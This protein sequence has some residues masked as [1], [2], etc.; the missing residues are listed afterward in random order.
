MKYKNIEEFKKDQG[1]V[2]NDAWYPRVTKICDV[3]NK[4][5]LYYFYAAASN[6][7]EANKMKQQAAS[8]GKIVHEIIESFISQ[9]PIIAPEDYSGFHKAFSDF[10]KHH[11]FFSK[12]EWLEKKVKHPY[13]RYVG[14]FDILAEIDNSFALIDIKTSAAVYDD[15]RL[16][17]AAYLFA[18]NEE[19]WLL[20][21]GNQKI[22]LPREVEKRYILRLNQKKICQKCGAVLKLRKMGDKIEN[23]GE[24]SNKCQHEFGEIVGEWELKEFDNPEEDFKGFLSCKGL[25][26]WEHRDFLK[27]IGYL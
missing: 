10:L 12:Y 4:P 3:K 9:K 8:E 27:E 7:G 22:V 6:F 15:Y 13:H 11:S 5:A 24:K 1:Y 23:N 20:G 14:T 18:I 16:Q 2:I 19:P 26:E 17:T 21:A 25:W